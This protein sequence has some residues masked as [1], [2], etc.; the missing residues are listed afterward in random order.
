MSVATIENALVVGSGSIARRHIRNLREQFPKASVACV[1]ASGRVIDPTEVGASEVLPDIATA[2]S[3]KPQVAIVASPAP[4]HL[5]NADEL[6]AANVPVLIEKP[7]CASLVELNTVDLSRHTAGIGIAYNLRFMPAANKVKTLLDEGVVGPISTA[8]A[9]VGQYLPDWRPDSDY[10]TGV[11]A[12]KEL[13]GGA[14]LELSHELDYLNWFFGPFSRALGVIR[15]TG[16]LDI[17]VEDNVDAL[18]EQEQGLMVH[19]HLDFNQRQPCRRFKAVGELGTIEWDLIANKV[20]LLRP[21]GRVEQVYADP[22]YDRNQMYVDQMNAFIRFT[23]GDVV[24][25]SSLASASG[26]MRLIESIRTS[27]K[28]SAW[29]DVR[30]VS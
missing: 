14:L 29:V 3:R 6:L 4:Y 13:G 30:A 15:S 19:V 25:G 28:H 1:S 8:I 23:Q 10:R 27:S 16:Q 20:S 26:V 5:R 22:T 12:R 17:D 2:I 21:G 24:F 7:L 11:S 9:E 18:L